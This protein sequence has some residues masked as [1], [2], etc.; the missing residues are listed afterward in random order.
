LGDITV[1]RINPDPYAGGRSFVLVNRVTGLVDSEEEAMAMVQALEG[2]GIATDDIDVFVGEQGARRLDLSGR[3]HGR[4]VRAWRRLEAAIGDESA[5]SRRI[6]EGLSR[7]GSL[8]CVTV[9]DRNHDV[10]PL[11]FKIFE[12]LHGYEIHYWGHWSF[13]DVRPVAPCAF[14]TLPGERI[15]DENEH[16]VWVLDIH[17]LTPGHSLIIPKLHTRTFFEATAEAQEAIL[18]LLGTARERISKD[19]APSGYNMGIDEGPAAGQVTAHLCVHLIPRYNGD[20][21]YTRGGLRC[22]IPDKANQYW[23]SQ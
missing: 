19:H 8:V 3:E 6:Q 16:A 11:A 15:L 22:V 1:A 5:P 10:K 7:G 21:G 23:S 14:C 20:G 2:G 18:T 13:E 4:I 12:A 17:P 9:H